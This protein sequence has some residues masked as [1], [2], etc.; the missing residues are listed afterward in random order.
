VTF[1]LDADGI[2]NVRA[3]DKDTGRETKAAM[4]LLGTNT[5]AAEVNA[6]AARQQRH[7]VA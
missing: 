7:I 5:D 3:K 6:M 4:R 2:L 1:E